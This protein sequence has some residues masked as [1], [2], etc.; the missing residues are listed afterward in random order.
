MWLFSE[1]SLK[2]LKSKILNLLVEVHVIVVTRKFD[3]LWFLVLK[4]KISI[5]TLLVNDWKL[6]KINNCRLES[7][8]FLLLF[9]K[10]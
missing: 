3:C 8:A 5:Q 9:S 10:I 4:P 1:G 2:I 7:C 6:D